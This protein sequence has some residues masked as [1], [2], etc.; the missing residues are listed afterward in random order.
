[1]V[2]RGE[3]SAMKRSPS[4]N[5]RSTCCHPERERRRPTRRF[6]SSC[7]T[8]LALVAFVAL[9]ALPS[10]AAAEGPTREVLPVP[11]DFSIDVCGFPVLVHSEG[12][13]VVL[14]WT[15]ASG[16]LIT[17]QN[18]LFPGTNQTF[19]NQDTGAS[20]VVAVAGPGFLQVYRDGS[21]TF[22]G[23]GPWS[24]YPQGPAGQTGIFVTRGRWVSSTDA[25][26]NTSFSI[27]GSI[28]DV[29]AELGS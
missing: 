23:A 26:G 27:V 29:C 16:D 5:V 8:V 19:T 25:H 13:V 24:W 18:Q 17:R 28:V 7:F 2:G 9:L 21:N 22:V 14:T 10:R 11:P 1:M 20:F 4:M 6:V 12:K 15:D 3:E